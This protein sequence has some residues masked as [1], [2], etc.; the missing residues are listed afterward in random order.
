[1]LPHDNPACSWNTV[2]KLAPMAAGRQLHG[3]S[4]TKRVTI[5]SLFGIF[6]K[7]AGGPSKSD[8]LTYPALCASWHPCWGFEKPS[9]HLAGA[10]RSFQ[11]AS[12][13]AVLGA[14]SAACRCAAGY[15]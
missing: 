4:S 12:A 2:S 5:V 11:D 7:F 8:V 10:L 15:L 9:G 14:L 1:M 13:R 6:A 3:C